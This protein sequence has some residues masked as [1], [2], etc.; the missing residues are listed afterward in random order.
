M[1]YHL[2]KIEFLKQ[3]MVR[4]IQSIDCHKKQIKRFRFFLTVHFSSAF[5]NVLII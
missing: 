4:T 2:F 5:L 1:I 3:Q